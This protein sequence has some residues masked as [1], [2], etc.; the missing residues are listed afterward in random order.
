MTRAPYD[1]R[2]FVEPLTWLTPTIAMGRRPDSYL[3]FDLVVSCEW[4]LARKPMSEYAGLTLHVPMLDEDNFQ[5]DE[6][7]DHAAV[8]AVSVAREG[9]KVLIHCTGGLNRSGVVAAR[10]L[11]IALDIEGREA[12]EIMRRRRDPF[13]LCNRAFERWIT[14]EQLPTAETSAFRLPEPREDDPA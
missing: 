13:C 12:V 14:G 8:M 2:E 5:L 4:H 10:A 11:M 6:R 3:G 1:P 9:G 7:I